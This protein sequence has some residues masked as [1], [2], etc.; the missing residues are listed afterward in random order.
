[1]SAQQIDIGWRRP[2]GYAALAAAACEQAIADLACP[3]RAI[4]A[5][6]R[7]WLNSP[8]FAEFLE[9]AGVAVPVAEVRRALRNSGKL[10]DA[11]RRSNGGPE[12]GLGGDGGRGG[13]CPIGAGGW[14]RNW[15]VK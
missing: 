12:T 14:A 9:L 2:S 13:W 11:G 5:D 8:A 7:E 10:P 4:R 3:H 1:M 6:A 15:P